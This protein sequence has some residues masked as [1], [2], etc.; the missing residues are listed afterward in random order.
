MF[1]G[2]TSFDGRIHEKH[3]LYRHDNGV[4]IAVVAKDKP[5]FQIEVVG[6]D[7]WQRDVAIHH[8]G[9]DGTSNTNCDTNGTVYTMT[10]GDNTSG[11]GPSHDE[12]HDDYD[13]K[14]PVL[15]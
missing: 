1:G 10:I 13:T 3:S 15:M 2:K 9:T 12:L 14:A 6:T 7:A 8:A 11:S 4:F 5:T